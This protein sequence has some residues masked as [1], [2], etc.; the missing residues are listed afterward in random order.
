MTTYYLTTPFIVLLAGAE[1]ADKAQSGAQ[2]L[3]DQGVVASS[4]GWLA[5]QRSRGLG[6][7]VQVVDVCVVQS[8]LKAELAEPTEQV[9]DAPLWVDGHVRKT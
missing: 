9:V 4:E 6:R 8:H 3:P 2:H 1:V 7:D 5:D